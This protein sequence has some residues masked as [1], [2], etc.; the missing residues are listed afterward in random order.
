M[1]PFQR[2]A[3]EGRVAV[4]TFLPSLSGPQPPPPPPP[5]PMAK[6]DILQTMVHAASL[7]RHV[8]QASAKI[9]AGLPPDP[10]APPSPQEKFPPAIDQVHIRAL[11]SAIAAHPEELRPALLHEAHINLTKWIATHNGQIVHDGHVEV[12]DSPKSAEQLAAKIINQAVDDHDQRDVDAQE[13]AAE[14]EDGKVPK[15]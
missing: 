9:A 6:Q 14:E 13:A 4:N 7:A 2:A 15:A 12:A 10:P 3:A 1:D 11:S 8:E 5:H